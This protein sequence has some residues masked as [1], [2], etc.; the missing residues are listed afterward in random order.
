MVD[1]TE[2]PLEA[3]GQPRMSDVLDIV[4]LRSLTGV[5]DAGGFRRAAES[6]DLA[7]LA[8]S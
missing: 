5:A 1:F 4:A 7:A 8:I 6:L 3:T 2:D